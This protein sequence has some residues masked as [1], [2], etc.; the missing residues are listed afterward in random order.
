MH[1]LLPGFWPTVTRRGVDT[2]LAAPVGR[3]PVHE[4]RR[5]RA[6]PALAL[7]LLSALL[8]AVACS[9]RETAI[10]APVDAQPDTRLAIAVEP[11]TPVVAWVSDH[12]GMR[13]ARSRYP[14]I[15]DS[16]EMVVTGFDRLVQIYDPG[17]PP[18]AVRRYF[19]AHGP[20]IVVFAQDEAVRAGARFRPPRVSTGTTTLEG[21]WTLTTFAPGGDGAPPASLPTMLILH[22]SSW[23]AGLDQFGAYLASSGLVVGVVRYRPD[24]DA[25]FVETPI[26][27]FIPALD[28]LTDHPAG[29]GHPV[30][31]GASRG[32]EAAVLLAR[33]A[34]EAVSGVIGLAGYDHVIAGGAGRCFGSPWTV[35]GKP[36]PFVAPLVGDE[37][38]RRR[39]GASEPVRTAMLRARWI[40]AA[41]PQIREAARL[42]PEDLEVD[43]LMI[44]GDDDGL[45]RAARAAR[46]QAARSDGRVCA[47][48]FTDVGHNV[49]ATPWA[50]LMT[51]R[52]TRGDVLLDY[53]GTPEALHAAYPRV[54]EA[55]LSFTRSPNCPSRDHRSGQAGNLTEG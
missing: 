11:D 36:A 27:G 24:P 6:A 30:L 1:R 26:E 51:T 50:T 25:C 39:V 54:N 2:G 23:D 31:V 41:P 43:T 13:F 52:R 4:C 14:A 42:R 37:Q 29:S 10:G 28:V 17:D 15:A 5:A 12:S 35:A 20:G 55:I 34:P 9:A 53:G 44:A 21:G 48:V 3:D 46:A 38:A 7:A 40:D 45:W 18:A 22:G 32:F 47:L 16:T 19:R 49:A 8:L 33:A